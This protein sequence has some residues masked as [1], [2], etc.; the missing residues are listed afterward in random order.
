MCDTAA[1]GD[2]QERKVGTC[3]ASYVG[4]W[5][6]KARPGLR[7]MDVWAPEGVEECCGDGQAEAALAEIAVCGALFNKSHLIAA[8]KI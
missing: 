3:G 1:R 2:C 8:V 6:A 4:R 7:S 5:K